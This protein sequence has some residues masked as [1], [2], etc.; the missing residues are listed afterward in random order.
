MGLSHILQPQMWRDYFTGLYEAGPAGVV[1]RTFSLELWPALVIVLLHPVWSGPGLVLTLYGWALLAKC[2]V[3]VLSPEIGL[4]SLAMARKGDRG[5][6]IG[7]AVLVGIGIS[8]GLALVM[9]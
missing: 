5:F 4:L 3:S 8:A 9:R 6:I 2:T 7:G 1:R